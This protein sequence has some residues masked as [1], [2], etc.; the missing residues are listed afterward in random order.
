MARLNRPDK[1][2]THTSVTPTSWT[3]EDIGR[4][5]YDRWDGYNRS[6]TKSSIAGY[7]GYHIVVEWDGTWDV[8]RPLTQEGIHARGQNFSSIGV[9][10]I[11]NGDRHLPSKAQREAW[12]EEVWPMI[13][14]EYPNIGKEDVFPHRKYANK[15]CHG[16]LLSDTYY[17]DLIKD[18]VVVDKS[19][20]IARLMEQIIS[21]LNVLLS[22]ERMK[23]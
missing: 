20:E 11:G 22:R 19:R 10:F 9:C 14:E 17:A 7:G 3:A 12:V 15:S 13:T 16:S 8:I 23:G 4:I 18:E 6:Q 1:V 2:I 5:H 21:L